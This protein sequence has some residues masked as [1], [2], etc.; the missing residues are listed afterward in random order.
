[1][2]NCRVPLPYGHASS[3]IPMRRQSI[4]CHFVKGVDWCSWKLIAMIL[5][6]VSL[7][8]TAALAYVVGESPLP[9]ICIRRASRIQIGTNVLVV[10][11]LV[12][13]A[14][15]TADNFKKFVNV[16]KR[17]SNSFV[18]NCVGKKKKKSRV[19]W[20]RLSTICCVPIIL[21][22]QNHW[23][24]FEKNWYGSRGNIGF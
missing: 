14:L 13:L 8:I 11:T 18:A 1:M 23:E 9:P 24:E 21:L 15:C 17:R 7:C 5:L 3:M 22:K 19:I 12:D 10:T 2:F 16:F 20:K 4:R 6:M